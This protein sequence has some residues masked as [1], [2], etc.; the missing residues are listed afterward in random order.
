MKREPTR[1]C[2]QQF[3]SSRR[4]SPPSPGPA[5]HHTAFASPRLSLFPNWVKL[6]VVYDRRPLPLA[7]PVVPGPKGHFTE[8]AHY[9][10]LAQVQ[11]YVPSEA[12]VTFIGEG[13]FDGPTLLA[14]V[15]S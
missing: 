6:N 2:P 1:N 13:E 10:L 14:T 8:A 9:A 15:P 5:E 3:P 11:P 4:Q 7:W 12:S